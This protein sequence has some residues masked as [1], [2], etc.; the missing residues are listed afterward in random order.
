MPDVDGSE[1]EKTESEGRRS[2]AARGQVGSQRQ[3]AERHNQGN[4]QQD[5]EFVNVLFPERF[6]RLRET[7]QR[8]ENR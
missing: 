5:D 7:F 8:K 3:Q 1:P 4:G 6:I 2:A